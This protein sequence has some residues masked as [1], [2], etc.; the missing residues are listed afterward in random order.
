MEVFFEMMIKQKNKFIDSFERVIVG[1]K[2]SGTTQTLSKAPIG[3]VYRKVYNN[4]IDDDSYSE[5]VYEGIQRLLQEP[6][7]TLWAQ[8]TYVFSSQEY[9]DCEVLLTE[10]STFS[11]R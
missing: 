7:T 1:S 9:I 6:S 8:D 11:Y 2:T 3:T 10:F 5:S 4:N